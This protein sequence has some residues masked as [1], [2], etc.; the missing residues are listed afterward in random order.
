MLQ[1]TSVKQSFDNWSILFQIPN[2][3]RAE[4]DWLWRRNW[5]N[6]ACEMPRIPSAKL[7]ETAPRIATAVVKVVKAAMVKLVL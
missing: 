6:T 4:V 1:F 2:K 7:V 3:F 5:R